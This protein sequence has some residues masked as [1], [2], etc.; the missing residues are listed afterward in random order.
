MA[1]RSRIA[2]RIVREINTM[3]NTDLKSIDVEPLFKPLRVGGLELSNRFG[4]SP[5]TRYFSPDGV[6][7]EGVAA[8]Y[9]RRAEGGV[10][11]IITEGTHPDH[12]VSHNRATTPHFYGESALAAWR[13]VVDEVHAGGGKIFP[14]LWH[15]GAL[16]SREQ[17]AN[18]D[19]Q[20]LGPS[21]SY[22][23]SNVTPRAMTEA[24]VADVIEAF[25]SAAADAKRVGFDGVAIH[26]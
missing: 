17:T 16:R 10:G 15:C 24:E 2:H 4:M 7:S 14:Q 18:P 1:A 8:Y 19:V 6:P 25:A 23:L 3:S 26:G 9:R 13:K 20:S 12:A 22:P 5:M 11:L 21:D